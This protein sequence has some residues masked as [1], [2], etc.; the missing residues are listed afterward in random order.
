MAAG[1]ML[2][3]TGALHRQF[4]PAGLQTRS[5]SARL[6]PSTTPACRVSVV[7]GEVTE[8][9]GFEQEIGN[10]LKLWLQP[11]ASGWIV[12]VIPA[13]GPIGDHDYAELAT[14]PYQ[15][16]T[17]LSLS[18]DFSFRAQDAVGW[19]PRRFH[20]ASSEAEFQ[21]L[22]EVYRRYEEA[23]AN[24][25]ATIEVE[26]GDEVA[27]ASEG[28]L[29][30][31]DARLVPGSADQWKMA[32]A[33]SNQ[34]EKTAH[35]LQM[36]AEGTATPLGK[37]VWLRFRVELLLSAGWRVPKGAKVSAHVCGSV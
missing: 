14:P 27:Q 2:G 11:I 17:P 32:A 26:L 21:R 24:P 29:T 6:R 37:L 35:S 7:E 15:S 20:F 12:R 31:V 23:G 1:L 34:F 25:P 22:E 28:K 19:N 3:S 30:I 9:K 10:G 36:P 33:V 13:A 8:G 18:T 5:N 16:V 4:G